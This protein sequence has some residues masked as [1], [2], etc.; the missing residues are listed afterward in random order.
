MAEPVDIA[1]AFQGGVGGTL[2][3]TVELGDMPPGDLLETILRA[4]RTGDRLREVLE[5]LAENADWAALVAYI[6]LIDPLTT[7]VRH[8]A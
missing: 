2:T 1:S 5:Y 6:H 7:I 8:V 3:A 4:W